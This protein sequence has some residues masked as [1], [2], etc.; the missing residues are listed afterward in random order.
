MK[1]FVWFVVL[2][3]LAYLFYSSA[4]KPASGEMGAVQ[5]LEKAFNRSTDRYI[6]AIR[7]AGE[8]GMVVLADP[9]FAERKV[10]E[11]RQRVLDLMKNMRDEKALERAQALYAKIQDFCKLNQIE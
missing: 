3:A 5:S 1:H 7:Q 9:D 8:P 6:S 4:V 2:G 11:V 10:R